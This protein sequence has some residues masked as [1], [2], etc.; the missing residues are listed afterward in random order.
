MGEPDDLVLDR[1][2]IARPDTLD[3][4]GEERRAVESRADDFVRARVRMRDPAGDLPRMHRTAPHEREHGR[5][6]VSGLH[7]QPGEVD[8]PAVEARRRAGLQPPNG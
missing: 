6:V 4:A 7:F 3:D 5:R 1:R 2:A 8:R